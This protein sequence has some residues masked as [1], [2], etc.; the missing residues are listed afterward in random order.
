MT[1]AIVLCVVLAIAGFLAGLASGYSIKD[2]KRAI[3]TFKIN[4]KDPS[5][6]LFSI[7]FDQDIT[8]FEDEQYVT[9][10][11]MKA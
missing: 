6:E 1:I 10:R 7:R 4:T 3:G 8:D 5:Q 11:V 2:N 9:F